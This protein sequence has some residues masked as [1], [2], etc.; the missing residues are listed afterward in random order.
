MPQGS[1][2]CSSHDYERYLDRHE[3]EGKDLPRLSEEEF[4]VLD[5]EL[6]GLEADRAAGGSLSSA[7][8]KR[9]RELRK[10]LLVD[11]DL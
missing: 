9:L 8:R 1:L 10:L 7:Q 2:F 3:W 5:E 11:V 4:C 6:M